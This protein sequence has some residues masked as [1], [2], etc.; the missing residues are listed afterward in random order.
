M[1]VSLLDYVSIDI[2]IYIYIY[3]YTYTILYSNVEVSP[4]HLSFY[5]EIGVAD[6][7]FGNRHGPGGL[8]P[9]TR[10]KRRFCTSF[11]DVSQCRRGAACAFA[12]SR[13]ECRDCMGKGGGKGGGGVG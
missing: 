10:R 7:A 9:K 11:P 3:I 8:A 1:Y 12:H 5:M 4:F 2:Y 13:E 6:L